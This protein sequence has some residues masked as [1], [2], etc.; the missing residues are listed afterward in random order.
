MSKYQLK[1]IAIALR[2]NGASFGEIAKRLKISKSTAS[3]WSADIELTK[4]QIKQLNKNIGIGR[5]KG[6]S[7]QHQKKIN[8]IKK[9]QE[10]GTTKIGVLSMRDW[11]TAGIGIYWGEGFK[12]ENKIGLANSDPKMVSFF[13][14]WLKRVFGIKQDRIIAQIRVNQIH[15]RRVTEIEKYW[16]N[17][18]QV[19]KN[20]FRKTI[21]L[22][23][24]NK[25]V[26]SNPSNHFGTITI[27]VSRSSSLL[28]QVLG[29]LEAMSNAKI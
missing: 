12:K 25:K 26:Y 7:T 2:K 28:Y 1:N 19:P 16:Q 4:S 29:L 18:I 13:I 27:K 5:L 23:V 14:R 11:L 8:K 6:S 24:K 20:Q 10:E 9:Y 17:I 3:L 15:A 22:K 21:L